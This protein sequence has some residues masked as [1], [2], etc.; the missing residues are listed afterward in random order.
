M[1]MKIFQVFR[2]WNGEDNLNFKLREYPQSFA[3]DVNQYFRLIK[4]D[5]GTVHNTSWM[6]FLFRCGSHFQHQDNNHSIIF[7]QML[8]RLIKTCYKW[9]VSPLKI[10]SF[11]KKKKINFRYFQLRN[12]GESELTWLFWFELTFE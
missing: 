3:P 9:H 10:Y 2:F 6:R 4:S 12:A 11:E 8:T 1:N 7:T 5:Y